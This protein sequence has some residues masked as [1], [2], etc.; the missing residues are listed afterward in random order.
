MLKAGS[1]TESPRFLISNQLRD[2]ILWKEMQCGRI[3]EWRKCRRDKL[4]LLFS[5]DGAEFEFRQVTHSVMNLKKAQNNIHLCNEKIPDFLQNTYMSNERVSFNVLVTS[6][7][8]V[9]L[10]EKMLHEIIVLK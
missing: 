1:D 5:Y 4:I 8:I 2:N 10:Y 9:G 7:I 6:I 3:F